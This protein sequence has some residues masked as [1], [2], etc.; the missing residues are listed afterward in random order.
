[1]KRKILGFLKF[2]IK[3]FTKKKADIVKK[4]NYSPYRYFNLNIPKH[5]HFPSLGIHPVRDTP[6][7]H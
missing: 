5:S 3:I 2:I 6:Y 1:M 7:Q 4:T